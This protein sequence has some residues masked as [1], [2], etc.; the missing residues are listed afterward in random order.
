LWR[1]VVFSATARLGYSRGV[2]LPSLFHEIQTSLLHELMRAHPLATLVTMA[3]DDLVADHIPMQVHSAPAPHGMLRGHVARANPLW[4]QHP[5]GREAL[6]VFQG[7]H[8][9]VSPAF[10]PTKRLTGE[11]VPTW[12]YAVVHVHGMLRFIHDPDALLGL[13]T[14]LT[15]THEAARAAPWQVSDAPARYIGRMLG[16]IVGFELL[17]TRMTGKWK[18]S[19]NRNAADRQ[20]VVDGLRSAADESSR[21]IADL[22]DRPSAP[23]TS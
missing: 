20:G 23:G 9:Y 5:A 8:A 21:A 22:V 18:V 6:V 3:A 12:N 4:R 7:P 17:I 15:D 19:Q 14:S 2:Y 13:V 11:V 1:R 16:E 10:Y